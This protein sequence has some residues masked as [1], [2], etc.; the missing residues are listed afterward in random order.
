MLG[1]FWLFGEVWGWVW[2]GGLGV[3]CGGVIF[4]GLV[5]GFWG[6]GGWFGSWG[7]LLVCGLF[8]WVGVGWVFIVV[9]FGFVGVGWG[10]FCCCG[11]VW[12]VG[13]LGREWGGID[14]GGGGGGL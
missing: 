10:C 4:G 8:C 2:G 6:V 13:V 11:M 14:M 7:V 9:V 5:L 12:G 3:V 1:W